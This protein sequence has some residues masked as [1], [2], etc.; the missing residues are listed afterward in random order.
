MFIS[1]FHEKDEQHVY[2]LLKSTVGMNILRRKYNI[3][4]LPNIK[5][6]TVFWQAKCFPSFEM[7]CLNVKTGC[8]G[9]SSPLSLLYYPF[10]QLQQ[11]LRRFSC[12]NKDNTL[13]STKLA[14]AQ[15]YLASTCTLST[16]L[17]GV[18]R[19]FAADLGA[20]E[21]PSQILWFWCDWEEIR[22]VSMFLSLLY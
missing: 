16:C 14:N 15:L 9:P 5:V 21:Y 11:Q 8:S 7:K 13:D 1:K 2:F 12:G 4:F 19:L 10:P 17:C 18:Q 20:A 6:T 22:P 3:S